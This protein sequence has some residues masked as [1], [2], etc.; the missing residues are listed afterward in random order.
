MLTISIS[1]VFL[2]GKL[3]PNFK[4]HSESDTRLLHMTN[5]AHLNRLIVDLQWQNLKAI[6]CQ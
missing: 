5:Q 1:V 2:I 6:L 3:L 4:L